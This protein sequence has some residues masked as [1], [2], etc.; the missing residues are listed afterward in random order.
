MIELI[1]IHIPKTA[2]RSFLAILNS[3]YGENHIS[4]YETNFFPDKSTPEILQFKSQ[5]K[6]D[7]R[8]IHGHFHYKEIQDIHKT[9]SSKVVT[10]LRDPVERVISNYSFFIKRASQPSAESEIQGRKNETLL[11]YARLDNSRN[12]MVK[13]MDGLNLGDFYFIGLMENFSGDIEVLAG[14]LNWK[15]TAVPR[16]NDN[17]EFK[18]QLPEVTNEERKIIEDL[19][20]E[21]IEL[22]KRVLEIHKNRK[23]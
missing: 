14:M 2:G 16:I 7:T 12:R 6:K 11:H 15:K 1:S 9:S 21:D 5:L 10:W 8:V 17:S 13:F 19:N 4:H 20:K 3:V 22:Y 18:L 23:T